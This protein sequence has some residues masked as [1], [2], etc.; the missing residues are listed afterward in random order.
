MEFVTES[1]EQE[2]TDWTQWMNKYIY[3]HSE[4]YKTF[5]TMGIHI[6]YQD[7]SG[8]EICVRSPYHIWINMLRSPEITIEPAETIGC[9]PCL[10]NNHRGRVVLNGMVIAIFD[11]FGK[12]YKY[13][14][15]PYRGFDHILHEHMIQLI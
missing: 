10:A 15:I 8:G 1:V 4:L 13:V 11:K 3:K 14:R 6:P 12:E 2:I 5:E 7:H 9:C